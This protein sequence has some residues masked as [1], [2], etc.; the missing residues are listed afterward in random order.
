MANLVLPRVQ[1]MVLCDDAEESEH[2]NGVYDLTG[3]RSVIE[4]PFPAVISRF[5]VFL[6]MSGHHGEAS[7]HMEI[8]HAETGEVISETKAQ[9]ISFAEPTSVVPVVFQLRN[10]VFPVPG[11]YYVQAFHETK[12]I[13]ERMLHLRREA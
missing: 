4:A 7:C 3:V 6:N 5:C 12:L 10:C 11:I 8:E 13:G 2:E 9:T 1:A